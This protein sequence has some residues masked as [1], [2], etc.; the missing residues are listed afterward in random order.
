[1]SMSCR[2]WCACCGLRR[3]LSLLRHSDTLG[4]SWLAGTTKIDRLH[5]ARGYYFVIMT[6]LVY[7]TG[8]VWRPLSSVFSRESHLRFSVELGAPHRHGFVASHF[9]LPA[10]TPFGKNPVRQYSCRHNRVAKFSRQHPYKAGLLIHTV[11]SSNRIPQI[12]H[13]ST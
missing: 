3:L 13:L 12:L 4:A 1:M 6:T 9:R 2:G 7:P 5:F 8:K 11:H 10:V